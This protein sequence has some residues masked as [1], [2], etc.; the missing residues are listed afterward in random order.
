MVYNFLSEEA[1]K[2]LHNLKN[3]SYPLMVKN[4]KL[5][6]ALKVDWVRNPGQTPAL[7]WE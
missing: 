7:C 3:V 1:S 6:P 5:S 4:E 2:K